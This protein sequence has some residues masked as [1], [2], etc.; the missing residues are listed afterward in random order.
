MTTQHTPAGNIEPLDKH[1]ESIEPSTINRYRILDDVQRCYSDIKGLRCCST[2]LIDE[3]HAQIQY[4]SERARFSSTVKCRSKA[5]VLCG[6]YVNEKNRKVAVEALNRGMAS[7]DVTVLFTTLTIPRMNDIDA[8]Y[9]LLKDI[10]KGFARALKRKI[11]MSYIKQV[12]I[13]F[14]LG[15]KG[16]YHQHLHT[17][18]FLKGDRSSTGFL[19]NIEANIKRIWKRIASNMGVKVSE[20]GQDIQKL[21]QNTSVDTMAE[22]V[23]KITK[24]DEDPTKITYEITSSQNKRARASESLTLTE[25][26]SAI[27]NTKGNNYSLVEMYK[28]FT[29]HAHRKPFFTKARDLFEFLPEIEEETEDISQVGAPQPDMW[30]DSETVDIHRSLFKMITTYRL[31]G[32]TVEALIGGMNNKGP[33]SSL[34]FHDMAKQSLSRPYETNINVLTRMRKPFILW[35]GAL[36]QEGYLTEYKFNNIIQKLEVKNE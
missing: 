17:L 22:Y 10:W 31:R 6:S 25:L 28:A 27:Y 34:T 29:A 19:S 15:N 20:E 12:D 24:G 16:S 13:T 14:G 33:L 26:M 21:D 36:H 8:Q 35:L 23:V 3:A 7:D 9:E 5:C 4:N 2:K 11:P 18:L 30:E 32:E 1:Y